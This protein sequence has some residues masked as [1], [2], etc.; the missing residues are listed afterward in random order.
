[1]TKTSVI[2]EMSLRMSNLEQAVGEMKSLQEAANLKLDL[3]LSNLSKSG[4]ERAT[5][6]KKESTRRESPPKQQL[7][8]VI[9]KSPVPTKSKVQ[10]RSDQMNTSIGANLLLL[11]NNGGKNTPCRSEEEVKPV[12]NFNLKIENLQEI[13]RIIEEDESLKSIEVKKSPRSPYQKVQ[14]KGW[15]NVQQ[16]SGM[17]K[18]KRL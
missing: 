8:A 13:D 3:I 6:P 14:R 7:N 1:M 10:P 18:I 16:P 5:S 2:S 12:K 4:N 17:F 11:M 9:S 15:G